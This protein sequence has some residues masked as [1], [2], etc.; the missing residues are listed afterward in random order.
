VVSWFYRLTRSSGTSIRAGLSMPTDHLMCSM[1][2]ACVALSVRFYLS[3]RDLLRLR[4]VELNALGGCV[5]FVKCISMP[6]VFSVCFVKM[7]N[8]IVAV[9]S[10][11][12][13]HV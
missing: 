8:I 6:F 11:C 13:M 10:L 1:C 3:W 4:G 7:Y 12:T 9:I 5:C 2:P